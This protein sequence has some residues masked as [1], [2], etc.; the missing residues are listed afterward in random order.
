MIEDNE[1]VHK[2]IPYQNGVDNL[3]FLEGQGHHQGYFEIAFLPN[4][5]TQRHLN[6]LHNGKDKIQF[7]IK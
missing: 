6:Y 7:N 3:L 1:N 4:I 5:G 2:L